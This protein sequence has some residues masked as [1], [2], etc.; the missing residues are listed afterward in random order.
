MKKLGAARSLQSCP[1]LCDPIDSS[2]PGSPV[3][4]ILQARTLEWVAISLQTGRTAWWGCHL[5]LANNV[6]HRRRSQDFW[7]SPIQY[8]KYGLFRKTCYTFRKLYHTPKK[9]KKRKHMWNQW[10]YPEIYSVI[11][12]TLPTTGRYS[13]WQPSLPPRNTAKRVDR[14]SILLL[15]IL[16]RQLDLLSQLARNTV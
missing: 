9:K 1:T 6:R 4:G 7:S 12:S 14:P 8:S 2:P 5:T 11:L 15:N 3:P 10:P 13:T 16:H